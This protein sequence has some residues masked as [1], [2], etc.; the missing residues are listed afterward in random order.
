LRTI[1]S[2]WT[3]R[4][5]DTKLRTETGARWVV[6]RH[7]RVGANPS[8]LIYEDA[9]ILL[10]RSFFSLIELLNGASQEE[11]GRQTFRATGPRNCEKCRKQSGT[12]SS[13]VPFTSKEAKHA[14]SIA[15]LKPSTTLIPDASP[16]P[17]PRLLQETGQRVQPSALITLPPSQPTSSSSRTFFFA[18]RS[19]RY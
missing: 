16:E 17:S 7:R 2:S 15:L 18:M 5:R 10:F 19:C 8:S 1:E 12:I 14:P 13:Q 9:K 4:G 3:R 11:I 6:L